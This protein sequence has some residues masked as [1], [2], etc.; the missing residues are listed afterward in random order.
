ME[1]FLINSNIVKFCVLSLILTLSKNKTHLFYNVSFLYWIRWWYLFLWHFFSLTHFGLK[2]QTRKTDKIHN[3]FELYQVFMCQAVLK[4]PTIYIIYKKNW[5]I[6]VQRYYNILNYSKCWI[7]LIIYIGKKCLK[8][9]IRKTI[10]SLKIFQYS[11]IV[12]I[13]S[14]AQ[15]KSVFFL[16]SFLLT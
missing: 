2:N 7:I 14:I 15:F 5:N 4:F 8:Y 3:N 16:F 6:L 11:Q 10:S 13:K 1:F 9:Q 12:Y